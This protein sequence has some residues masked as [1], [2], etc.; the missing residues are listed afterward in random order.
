MNK[1]LFSAALL[2]AST[3]ALAQDYVT[4]ADL[5]EQASDEMYSILTQYNS[6]MMQG[7][8]EAYPELES[9]QDAAN[10]VMQNCETHLDDLKLHLTENNVEP[11]LVEGMAKKMRSR[12]ARQLMTRT[13][14]NL[15]AQAQAAGN[16]EKMKKE[17]EVAE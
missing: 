15:A 16:A 11:S 5:S 10:Q 4:P 14:N 2:T 13:M 17:A 9:G 1:F 7:R 12:S 3:V 8:L 6:C